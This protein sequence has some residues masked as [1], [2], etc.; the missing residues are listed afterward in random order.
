MNQLELLWDYQ[1][2]DVEADNI[3]K[4]IARS[5]QRLKLLKMRED[6]QSQQKFLKTLENEVL[7]MLDRMEVLKEAIALKGEQ[8]KQLQ[9]KVQAAPAA[10]SKEAREYIQDM[11]KLISGLNEYEQET[12]RIRK[13]A[14]ERD[15]KQRDIKR[16]AVKIKMDFDA[17]RDEYNAEY[18]EKS[19][20]ME[21]R[22]KIADEKAKLVAPEMLQKYNEVKQHSVPPMARLVNDRCSG[23]NMSFPSSVLHEIKA[24]KEVECETCGRMIIA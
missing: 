1:L 19:K 2:A 24:G 20:E 12:R 4:E 3:K 6:I 11:Q 22:R 17:L 14:A 15:V 8:L 23:C 9:E 21:R 5:P 10:D 13:D 18:E 16:L 7:A